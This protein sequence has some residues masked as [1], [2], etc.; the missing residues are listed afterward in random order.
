M[1]LA[2]LQDSFFTSLNEQQLAEIYVYLE[3][4]FPR[5]SDPQ[6]VAG[7][8]HFVGPRESVAHLRDGLPQQIVNRGTLA[9]VEAMRWIVGKLPKLDWLQFRL[10]EAQQMMRMKTWAL[11]TPKELFRLVASKRRLLVQSGDD[12]CELLTEALRKYECELHGEQ[13]PVRAL[14]DRQESGA[15]FRPVEE[16]SL[17]DNVSLF[18][19][20][21]LVESGIVA[22]REVEIARVPGAPI[23]KR[24]DIRIDEL[25]RSAGGAAYDA[26]TA[27]IETKGCWNAALFTALKDQLYG[28]Y[29]IRLRAPVGIYLVGW[30]DKAKWDP[31][32]RRKRDAP[33]C[34]L[35]EAQDRLDAQAAAIPAGFLIRSVVVDC[36]AP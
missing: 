25:R 10:L 21:E 20:R 18:L 26:I 24:T 11:L 34:T 1:R 6:H 19:R 32:D 29:M 12:L 23:G 27:V 9:A 36:H 16:D 13:N 35:R 15:T 30:F 22:N 2:R 8:A 5:N 17:S 4:L 7:E 31:K 33:E 14:W 28:D 3:E